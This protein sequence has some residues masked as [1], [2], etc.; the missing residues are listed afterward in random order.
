MDESNIHDVT[1][2]KKLT[3]L[4]LGVYENYKRNRVAFKLFQSLWYDNHPNEKRP[5]TLLD[6]PPLWKDLPTHAAKQEGK[7][8]GKEWPIPQLIDLEV[9][10][11]GV[12]ECLIFKQ[13]G[14]LC[15]EHKWST[16]T[17]PLVSHE[18][19]TVKPSVDNLVA[20]LKYL[21]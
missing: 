4:P 10:C 11:N 5:L 18:K 21:S 13:R 3:L 2:E 12:N 20:V 8:L 6:L 19:A 14:Y 1:I 9:R 17:M 7:R 15:K 16:T